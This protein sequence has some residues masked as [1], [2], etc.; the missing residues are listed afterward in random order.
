MREQ[1]H[2]ARDNRAR[3]EAAERESAFEKELKEHARDD[4]PPPQKK[5]EMNLEEINA[6]MREQR[7]IARANRARAEAV[8]RGSAFGQDVKDEAPDDAPPPSK[9]REMKLE[10]INA[11]MREQRHIARAN[12]AR[13]EAAERPSVVEKQINGKGLKD[14]A[15]PPN[16]SEKSPEAMSAEELDAYMLRQR[17]CAKASRESEPPPSTPCLGEETGVPVSKENKPQMSLAEINAFMRE[18][19]HAMRANRAK[20]EAAPTG[21]NMDDLVAQAERE[22]REP[23]KAPPSPR[24]SSVPPPSSG[25]P[26]G[27]PQRAGSADRKSEPHVVILDQDRMKELFRKQRDELK[28]NRDRIRKARDGPHDPEVLALAGSQSSPQMKVV[29][30]DEGHDQEGEADFSHALNKKSSGVFLRS[31]SAVL[32]Q[33]QEPV[34]EAEEEDDSAKPPRD[35]DVILEQAK[36]LNE[37]LDISDAKEVCDEPESDPQCGLFFLK[38]RVLKFPVVRDSDSLAYRA[39]AIR[40]FLEREMGLDKVLALKQIVTEG[41]AGTEVQEVLRDCEPGLVIL[42]QQ[43]LVLEETVNST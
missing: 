25:P 43:M 3:A 41:D 35:L 21:I 12:R 27:A 17:N 13:A 16:G 20:A 10:E 37:A 4:D 34:G 39:E 38:D 42:A 28:R 15:C 8:E 11:Y 29:P 19:R 32:G 24:H 23:V 40:A 7:H 18:Q 6:Y 14:D 36:A 2:I 22:Q 26:S 9:K 5:R 31:R 33:L 30:S 1:R